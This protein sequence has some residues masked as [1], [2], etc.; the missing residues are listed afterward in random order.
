MATFAKKRATI[1]KQYEQFLGATTKPEHEYHTKKN[2]ES[3]PNLSSNMK[4]P[5]NMRKI[6]SNME[7]VA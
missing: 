7:V 3:S 2:E 1:Q 5:S 4:Y 6:V